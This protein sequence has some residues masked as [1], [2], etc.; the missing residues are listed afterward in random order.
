MNKK[1]EK[2]AKKSRTKTNGYEYFNKKTGTTIEEWRKFEFTNI[3]KNLTILGYWFNTDK[4]SK[5]QKCIKIR[6]AVENFGKFRLCCLL[7]AA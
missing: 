6:K 3:L 1:T 2:C 7:I 5:C 4:F